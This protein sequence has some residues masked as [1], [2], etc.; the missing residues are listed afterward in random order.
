[1]KRQTLLKNVAFIV[2]MIT[3]MAYAQ[4]PAG[5]QVIVI[6]SGQS[7]AGL[8]ETTINGDKD[9]NGD[10][11]NPNRIYQLE[12]GFHFV[13]SAIDVNNDTGTITIEGAAG[14]TKPV[15]IPLVVADV[16][17]ARNEINSNLTLKN[18]HMQGRNTEGAYW[19]EQMWNVK[20]NDRSLIVED[21]VM[22]SASR[23][24]FL[25]EVPQGLT[26]E[27]RNNYFRDFHNSSQPWAGNVMDAKNVPIE[28]FIFENNTV[29]N[30]NCVLLLQGNF[31][32]YTLINHNTFINSS[33]FLTLNPYYYEA[34][35]TNNLYYNCNMWGTD[36][37]LRANDPDKRVFPI[38]AIDTLDIKIGTAA[39][40]TYAKNSDET[41]LVAPYNDISNYKIYLADNIYHNEATLDPY[42]TGTYNTLYDAPVSYLSWYGAGPHEVDVP[43]EWTAARENALISDHAGI[44]E[45]NNILDQDPQMVTT[46]IST[47]TAP[48]IAIWLRKMY[49]V[50]DETGTPD[51]SSYYFGDFDPLT[52]PGIETEDG[53][54]VTKISDFI[55]DF[56]IGSAFKSNID[57]LSIGALHWTSE[58]DS[59]DP[60]QGLADIISA[61]N[62]SLSV[63][64]FGQ[65][66][67]FGLK[68]YP[69]PS[70][71]ETTIEFD[72]PIS[73]RL[74]ISIYNIL[75]V[76]IATLVNDKTYTAGKHTI[77]WN[78]KKLNSGLYFCKLTIEDKTQTM[79]LLITH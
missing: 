33:T 10:R 75:G 9:A 65:N 6:P 14:G 76:Q 27:F 12:A 66:N 37:T 73:T 63:D 21:C 48:Q 67:V 64:D 79:K 18:V 50:P 31:V 51:L 52:I 2:T 77:N 69:N 30:G 8:L 62:S 13:Q 26:M 32:K 72:I 49:E 35:I 54:G 23:G 40:P 60:V 55:E 74:N 39:I 47:T 16:A 58:I 20:G 24:F 71:T 5:Q 56:S 41:A 61:Y 22:E 53:A 3:T 17:P 59:Y 38:V 57:G 25:Q 43:A 44:I 4:V 34:Y 36:S 45:E 7:N 78:T 11:I 68:G 70:D 1:M 29:S 19:G 15:I 28:S 46:A 42:Y